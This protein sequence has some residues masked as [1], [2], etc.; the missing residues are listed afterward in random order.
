MVAGLLLTG[1]KSRRMRK[2][3]A[4]LT[5][6]GVTFVEI[7]SSA[8]RNSL[9]ETVFEV[10][11]QFSTFPSVL[12]NEKGS[13]PLHAVAA[14][15]TAIKNLGLY[16]PVIV[17]TCDMPYVNGK[18]VN[19]LANFNG[20]AGINGVEINGVGINGAGMSKSGTV[21]VW[22]DKSVIPVVDSFIQ[23]LCARW[24]PQDLDKILELVES[25][26]KSMKSAVSKDSVFLEEN[27]SWQTF[28]GKRAFMD[29]DYLVDYEKLVKPFSELTLSEN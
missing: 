15:W 7:V 24:S 14:G 6:N 18:L 2:D 25:G 28:G 27:D 8:F 20:V 3:K 4:T 23:P 12:E 19:Y 22:K 17:L 21:E 13:G 16:C 10:G 9:V 11:P 29:V 5:L 26:E 1:G